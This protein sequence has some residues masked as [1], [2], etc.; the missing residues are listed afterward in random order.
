MAGFQGVTMARCQRRATAAVTGAALPLRV[1]LIP[2]C[3]N[4][5]TPAASKL[6]ADN[7]LLD[8]TGRLALRTP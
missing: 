8:T 4:A 6:A 1:T 2:G 7:T 3:G 5:M